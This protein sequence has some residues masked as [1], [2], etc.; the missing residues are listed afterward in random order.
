MTITFALFMIFCLIL[1]SWLTTTPAVV[2]LV[3]YNAGISL[4]TEE[5]SYLLHSGQ[6]IA[7]SPVAELPGG[8]LMRAH[9]LGNV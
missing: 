8:S 7:S 2:L 9:D 6:A 1:L 4:Q 3:D 5:R